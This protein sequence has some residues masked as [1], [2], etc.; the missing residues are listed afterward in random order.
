M[1]GGLYLNRSGAEQKPG[2]LEHRRRSF[3]ATVPAVAQT[4]QSYDVGGATH[5][6][7]DAAT[8]GRIGEEIH[9]RVALEIAAKKRLLF[10]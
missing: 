3:S 8:K 5:Q 7:L 6:G 1:E 10:L 9:E 2:S 4:D